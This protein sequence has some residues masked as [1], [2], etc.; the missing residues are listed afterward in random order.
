M[1]GGVA[2][3]LA[4]AVVEIGGIGGADVAS[5][6]A[7]SDL[8]PH[9]VLPATPTTP[10][11]GLLS[12]QEVAAVW[13]PST[14]GSEA[15]TQS[16]T[17][18]TTTSVP[19][20]TVA[21]TTTSVPPKAVAAK[22]SPAHSSTRASS[23]TAHTSTTDSSTPAH[24]PTDSSSSSS[25]TTTT[26]TP[27]ATPGLAATNWSGYVL[28]GGGYQ[29]VS[30][31]W[32]VPTLNCAVVPNGGTSDWVGV[33]G[34]VD[35][36]DLFQGGTSSTCSGGSQSNVAVWSDGALGYAWQ[37]QFTVSAGDVISA[38]VQQSSLGTWTATVTDVT[39]G[40]SATAS[41]SAVY[42]GS[43]A[44]WIAEDSGVQGSSNLTPLA[45][46][47][48]VTFTNLGVVPTSALTYADAIEMQTSG[49]TAEA[50]PSQPQGDT[51][52]SVSYEPAG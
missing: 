47:G 49:G 38:Q 39:T 19:P 4:I 32:T 33:N 30:G 34:W 21:P 36:A 48:V 6:G 10:S 8:N 46:F 3:A 7:I 11:G 20:T 18:V 17:A 50:M 5:S 15:T 2:V 40:Q 51:S 37:Q 22:R 45:D 43:S 24:S 29:V 42:A 26:T 9:F 14:R 28:T 41:E 1:G 13:R 23:T 35:P 27:A 16:A 25:S 52:F 44:E 12:L 31:E